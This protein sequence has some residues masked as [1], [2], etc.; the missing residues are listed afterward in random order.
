MLCAW[1]AVLSCRRKST[2]RG[3][4]GTL[5]TWLKKE[6]RRL[7]G[8]GSLGKGG[9][10]ARVLWNTGEEEVQGGGSV[11]HSYQGIY[12]GAWWHYFQLGFFPPQPAGHWLQTAYL[13]AC[14]REHL[15]PMVRMVSHMMLSKAWRATVSSL[16]C[17][18]SWF[19]LV[20]IIMRWL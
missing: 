4:R 17:K 2:Q 16:P 10:V 13:S 19:L 6:K 15:S 18:L 8:L 5:S 7:E 3:R 1:L 20:V 11:A 12:L 14:E 9:R